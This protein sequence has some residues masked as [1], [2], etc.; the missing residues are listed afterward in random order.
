MIGPGCER[1]GA[2]KRGK[3]WE[4]IMD[5]PEALHSE[6]VMKDSAASNLQSCFLVFLCIFN[7]DSKCS[8]A[9]V[10]LQEEP[11]IIANKHKYSGFYISCTS[12]P[13]SFGSYGQLS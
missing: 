7:L 10:V 5:A 11:P 8:H 12:I 13:Q 2:V 9:I 4:I 1:V 6:D 3:I